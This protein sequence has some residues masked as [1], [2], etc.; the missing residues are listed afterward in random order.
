M[1]KA[2]ERESTEFLYHQVIIM[3]K[4]MEKSGALRVGDKLP[5][6]RGLSDKL[7]V[8]IPTVRQAYLELER[9][10]VIEARP[11]SG[12]FLCARTMTPATLKKAR[13]AR[14]PH[15]VNR[16]TLIEQV[17][18]AIHAPGSM[19][20]G[21]ANPSMAH[22]S[23]KGLAR[24]MRRVLSNAGSKAVS[25]G[26]M[27][28]YFPLKRQ[29]ALRYMDYGLHVDP[30]E[31]LITNGAQEAIAIALKCV[32]N[33]GDVIAVES[34]T[35]FGVLE[36][37]ESLGMMA[38]E[39]PLCP[40]EGILPQDLIQAL[41]KHAVKACVFSSAI[42]NPLGSFM[43]D[44]RRAQIVDI[45]EHRG[46]PFIE[47][48]VY[49][50]LFFTPKRGTPARCFSHQG[51]VLSCSSFSKTIA[52]GYRIGWLL[53]GKYQAKAQR[54]KRALS[55]SSSLLNQWTLAEFVASG[56]YDRSVTALRQVLQGNRQMAMNLVKEYFPS[57]TRVSC[58]QGG[59]VL[60]LELPRS[61]DG[62]DLFHKALENNISITPGTLFSSTDK[63]KHCIRISYGLN[64]DN[65]VE[66]S[67]KILGSL[68]RD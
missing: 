34:P 64:W 62:T 16:Q 39:I 46:I 33:A 19:P 67:F 25:Y 17:F 37:I 40:E 22:P 55:C 38:L 29:L 54:I 30:D 26:P 60:W 44:E 43:C 2:I 4:E 49:G 32:A 59:G 36:L 31:V 57:A 8:S 27:H 58:P 35:Y 51:G 13:P 65:N 42:S 1:S 10:G 7:Q 18:D 28:G 66:Q 41:D 63:F 61:N 52:P 21:A 50:D 45:L 12:Y 5:S 48:D 56:E 9:Q 23:D 6:L 15:V 68:V 20:L 24:V 14:K 53:A 11:K 3:V 47:D